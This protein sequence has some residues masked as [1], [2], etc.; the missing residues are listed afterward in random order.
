MPIRPHPK[1]AEH[2]AFLLA[3]HSSTTSLAVHGHLPAWIGDFDPHAIDEEHRWGRREG[4]GLEGLSLLSHRR[5]NAIAR[6]HG[7]HLAQGRVHRLLQISQTQPK[8]VVHHLLVEKGPPAALVAADR[9]P[10]Q[11]AVAFA[12]LGDPQ[13][14]NAALLRDQCAAVAAAAGLLRVASPGAQVLFFVA[15]SEWTRIFNCEF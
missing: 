7:Q 1:R 11:I 2:D 9:L 3:L 12:Q 10:L 8:T 14:R 6:G 4:L 15:R 5:D 13:V